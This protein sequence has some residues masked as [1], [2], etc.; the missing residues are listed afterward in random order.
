MRLNV[1]TT[2]ASKRSLTAPFCQVFPAQ[3]YIKPRDRDVYRHRRTVPMM[4]GL[5]LCYHS[6]LDPGG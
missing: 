6:G 3:F 2:A 1:H 5:F 4:T